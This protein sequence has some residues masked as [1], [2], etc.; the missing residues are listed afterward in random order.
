MNAIHLYFPFRLSS[1]VKINFFA[2]P[3]RRSL[4]FIYNSFR[5]ASQSQKLVQTNAADPQAGHEVET[6]RLQGLPVQ[7]HR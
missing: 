5:S 3:T 7:I 6:V 1:I 2:N 4:F